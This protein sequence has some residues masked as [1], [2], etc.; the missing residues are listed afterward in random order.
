MKRLK[1]AVLALLLFATSCGTF[2]SSTIYDRKV[3]YFSSTILNADRNVITLANQTVWSIDHLTTVVNLS[4][5]FI[6]LDENIN[7][8]DM[9]IGNQKFRIHGGVAEDFFFQYGYLQIMKDY[10]STHYVITLFN[11]S[12]WEI[13][14]PFSKFVK[15][16]QNGSE[17]VITE[18]ENYI[19]NARRREK[20]PTRRLPEKKSN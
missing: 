4:P 9:Y 16:W 10:D 6:V 18:N 15:K 17:V 8:G 20:V 14:K 3:R 11:N 12:K 19:I 5:V 13:P 1:Y 2:E 7:V